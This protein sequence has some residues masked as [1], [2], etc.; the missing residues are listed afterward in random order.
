MSTGTIRQ[1]KNDQVTS[2]FDV[3]VRLH[4]LA[5]QQRE[6]AGHQLLLEQQ[7]HYLTSHSWKILK[8]LRSHNRCN[9]VIG[10]EHVGTALKNGSASNPFPYPLLSPV[11]LA[12]TSAE[13]LRSLGKGID[14][15]NNLQM[16]L[17]LY[18]RN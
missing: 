10:S 13:W 3:R 4:E 2:N 16:I 12:R 9:H 11:P 14:F 1:S 6:A 8:V 18:D 17:C 7:L 5:R 15:V